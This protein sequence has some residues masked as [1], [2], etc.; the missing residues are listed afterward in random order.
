MLSEMILTDI[1]EQKAPATKNEKPLEKKKIDKA[2]RSWKYV[3]NIPHDEL[4]LSDFRT[5]LVRLQC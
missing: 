5:P 3:L 4:P 2:G 1:G